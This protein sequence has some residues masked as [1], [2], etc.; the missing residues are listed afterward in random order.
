MFETSDN[1]DD[2]SPKTRSYSILL[3]YLSP[4]PV[5]TRSGAVAHTHIQSC[6]HVENSPREIRLVPAIRH[7]VCRHTR[8]FYGFLPLRQVDDRKNVLILL[9]KKFSFLNFIHLID[10]S[11]K[12]KKQTNKH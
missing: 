5:T 7:V 4:C 9:G 3:D 11:E 1:D 2:D 8:Q 12:S 6:T 10:Y